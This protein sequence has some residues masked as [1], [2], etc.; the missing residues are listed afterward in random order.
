MVRLVV[1]LMFVVGCG[2][3]ATHPAA[4][5]GGGLDA[6]TQSEASA[7]RAAASRPATDG[8]LDA[9]ADAA[10]DAGAGDAPE[11][12]DGAARARNL[13]T[14]VTVGRYHV[15]ALLADGN[16]KC[17]GYNDYGELGL[18]STLRY[19]DLASQ[20]GDALPVVDLGTGRKALQIAAGRYCTCAI[21]DDHSLKCWGFALDDVPLDSPKRF[22][23][24][25]PGEMGDALPAMDLGPGRTAKRLATGNLQACVVRTTTTPCA[26]S[27]RG[28][29]AASTSPLPAGR[30]V[31]AMAARTASPCCST[32]AACTWPTPIPTLRPR[33]SPSTSAS[34]AGGA[35]SRARSAR[36]SPSCSRAAASPAS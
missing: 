7:D 27:P 16:V 4:K 31:V 6:A 11:A 15:C 29:P 3:A 8:A 23:G 5:D 1:S 36:A 32:T 10:G 34:A 19:G 14:A 21:L 2:A 26:A 24:D 13:A 28:T 9:P 22:R 25:A 30:R 18:G 12:R 17:W 33:S 35:P 20:M